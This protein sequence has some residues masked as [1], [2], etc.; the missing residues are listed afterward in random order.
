VIL[1]VVRTI[2]GFELPRVLVPTQAARLAVT[3]S[4]IRSELRRGNWQRLACGIVLTRPDEPTRAD[5]AEVGVALAGPR[6]GV[7]GWD[8]LQV[9]GLGGR[10]PPSPHVLVLSPCG[11]NRVV[12]SVRIRRTTRAFRRHT[13]SPHA[14]Q[15]PLVPVVATA[16]AIADTALD[17]GELPAVRALVTS[18]VQR[19]AC[20]LVELIDELRACPRRHSRLFRL[21]LHDAVGGARSAAEAAAAARLSRSTVPRFELNVP[22]VDENGLVIFVV[23]VLWRELRAAL[24]ID[25]REYHFT[26]SDWLATLDRHNALTRFGLAVT[27]YPPSRV[28]RRGDGWTREVT[29]WLQSRAAELGVTPER[30]GGVV[31]PPVGQNPPP[32]VVRRR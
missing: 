30:G 18:A 32:F 21:A 4:M 6:S 17:H 20:T 23:D 25:S 15:L 12:G 31:A 26:E 13:M 1:D 7:S 10:N 27:H 9:R 8:A 16:R 11:M 2:R 3:R 14:A 24:E 28:T 5:W 19:R 22:I 29:Q